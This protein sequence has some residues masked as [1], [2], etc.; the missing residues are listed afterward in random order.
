MEFGGTV[1]Y[2]PR[3]LIPPRYGLR[4]RVT[5]D[6]CTR[7]KSSTNMK[8]SDSTGWRT[9]AIINVVWLTSPR[10][11]SSASSSRA[12]S[13]PV[14]SPSPPCSTR[15]GAE[16]ATSTASTQACTFFSRLFHSGAGLVQLLH[17]NP[18]SPT[19]A[20]VDAAHGRGKTMHIGI[21][22][23]AQCPLCLPLQERGMVPAAAQLRARC[24][25]CSTLPSSKSTTGRTTTFS[26]LPTRVFA[27]GEPYYLPGA[28]LAAAGLPDL[29]IG[30]YG[31]SENISTY[32]VPETPSPVNGSLSLVQNISAA[33]EWAGNWTRLEKRACATSI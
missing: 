28:S 20:E 10:L 21:A 5:T 32:Y 30:G 27:A 13:P 23:L 9:V 18:H 1:E 2:T 31:S 29:N 11:C 4:G 8:L 16:A 3:L 25:S 14:A 26:P 12:A 19:R 24:T 33:A 7:H 22:S 15:A 17:P 6:W